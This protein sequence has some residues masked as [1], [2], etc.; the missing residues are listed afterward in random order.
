MTENEEVM[1]GNV[2]STGGRIQMKNLNSNSN[3][4]GGKIIIE[5]GEPSIVA[6]KC[7]GRGSKGI[8]WPSPKLGGLSVE[9]W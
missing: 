2:S 8:Y 9:I 7:G 5:M 6:A 1:P 4:K 3:L